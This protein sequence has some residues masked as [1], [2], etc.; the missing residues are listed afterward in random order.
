MNILSPTLFVT[1]LLT[2]LVGGLHCTTMCGGFALSV[3]HRSGARGVTLYTAGRLTT[4]ALLGALGG[5][6][7]ALLLPLEQ[8]GAILSAL[9][10]IWFAARLAGVVR[11][12]PG[13]PRALHNVLG[14]L[15]R[16]VGRGGPLA[17]GSFT[18]LL[19]CGLVYAALALPVAGASWW[20]GALMMVAFGLGTTP[21]LTALTLG[22]ARMAEWSPSL[23]RGLAALVVLSGLW[24]LWDRWPTR[25]DDVPA[26]CRTDAES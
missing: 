7:G 16:F 13:L 3:M 10:L 8:V 5:G 15:G 23:R 24:A 25:P 17:L 20:Q 4:Y 1:A 14:P 18:A 22:G 9:L 11:P 2:G 21:A 26:C 12:M 19:P 6:F